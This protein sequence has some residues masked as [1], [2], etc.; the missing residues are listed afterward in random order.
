[1]IYSREQD[2]SGDHEF[3]LQTVWE[4][5]QTPPLREQNATS[6]YCAIKANF[7]LLVIAFCRVK[8]KGACQSLCD[9]PTLQLPL[10]S[11]LYHAPPHPLSH[12][13]CPPPCPPS[14]AGLHFLRVAPAAWGILCQLHPYP[15]P[16]LSLPHPC[17]IIF[18]YIGLPLTYI[19]LATYLYIFSLNP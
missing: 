10:C 15:A 1:M 7:S 9:L 2:P 19:L 13:Q 16:A 14:R 4:G 3:K 5:M 12:C 8:A 17:F 11:H 18:Y 6:G